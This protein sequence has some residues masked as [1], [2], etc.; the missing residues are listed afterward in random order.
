MWNDL[1]CG[2][3]WWPIPNYHLFSAFNPSKCTHSSEHTDHTPGAGIKKKII[4]NKNKINLTAFPQCDTYSS[5]KII[6]C[7]LTTKSVCKN[8][9]L[10]EQDVSVFIY[11]F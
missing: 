6:L 3:V 8:K 9:A 10:Q 4:I 1:T 11:V 7:K 5:I 2:Q